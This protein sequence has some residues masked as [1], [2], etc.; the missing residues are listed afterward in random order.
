MASTNKLNKI[1]VTLHKGENRLFGLCRALP[2]HQV[3]CEGGR[4]R[5]DSVWFDASRKGAKVE[6]TPCLPTNVTNTEI[7]SHYWTR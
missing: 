3:L 5:I 7:E 2:G 1:T 6:L 4:V